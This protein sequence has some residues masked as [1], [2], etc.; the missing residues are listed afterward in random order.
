MSDA[1]TTKFIPKLNDITDVTTSTL[2]NAIWERLVKAKIFPDMAAIDFIKR[3]SIGN[4]KVLTPINDLKIVVSTLQALFKEKFNKCTVRESKLEEEFPGCMKPDLDTEFRKQYNI[5]DLI[6]TS[7]NKNTPKEIKT[8][9]AAA[10]ASAAPVTNPVVAV[11]ESLA[12]AASAVPVKKNTTIRAAIDALDAI[13]LTD[14]PQQPEQPLGVQPQQPTNP[15]KESNDP[16]IFEDAL[17]N[18][19][20]AVEAEKGE[21]QQD[22]PSDP[23]PPPA[24][25]AP[26]TSPPPPLN[27]NGDGDGDDPEEMEDTPASPSEDNT[28]A[29]IENLCFLSNTI[30]RLKFDC[31]SSLQIMGALNLANINLNDMSYLEYR[32]AID[33]IPN[34]ENVMDDEDEMVQHIAYENSKNTGEDIEGDT[35]FD[36]VTGNSP[37]TIAGHNTEVYGGYCLQ[38]DLIPLLQFTETVRNDA[39][40]DRKLHKILKDMS[41]IMKCAFG[42]PEDEF[43]MK[44]PIINVRLYDNIDLVHL[45]TKSLF[46]KFSFNIL[47]VK[48]D[49]LLQTRLL[50]GRENGMGFFLNDYVGSVLQPYFDSII[51]GGFGKVKIIPPGDTSQIWQIKLRVLKTDFIFISI[52]IINVKQEYFVTV[53]RGDYMVDQIYNTVSTLA[54]TYAVGADVM[55]DPETIERRIREDYIKSLNLCFS[56]YNKCLSKDFNALCSLSELDGIIAKMFIMNDPKSCEIFTRYIAYFLDN[57][58]DTYINVKRQYFYLGLYNL[59]VSISQKI[60]TPETKAYEKLFDPNPGKNIFHDS[61]N[62]IKTAVDN[63]NLGTC[64]PN[65]SSSVQTNMSEP[66]QFAM[67]GGKLYSLYQKA[68]NNFNILKIKILDLYTLILPET[69]EFEKLPSLVN[70][71]D[72]FQ[73]IPFIQ[74]YLQSRDK[75]NIHLREKINQL[76]LLKIQQKQQAELMHSLGDITD[77]S[78]GLNFANEILSEMITTLDDELNNEIGQVGNDAF[79]ILSTNFETPGYIPGN[80]SAIFNNIL[81]LSTLLPNLTNITSDDSSYEDSILDF[82]KKIIPDKPIDNHETEDEYSTGQINII[83]YFLMNFEIIRYFYC[84]NTTKDIFKESVNPAADADFSMFY[85]DTAL[86]ATSCMTICMI[87]QLAL[88]DLIDQ[89]VILSSPPNEPW[90]GSEIDIGNSCIGTPPVTLSSLRIVINNSVPFYNDIP[91]ETGSPYPACITSILSGANLT[92]VKSTISPFGPFAPP[93][94]PSKAKWASR[95]SSPTTA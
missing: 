27:D 44:Q 50:A 60:Y 91:P 30:S 7:I 10:T 15:Q 81:I 52:Q 54:T 18:I 11:S 3:K 1:Y 20:N 56:L 35:T 73:N 4:E 49:M 46:P 64:P 17:T 63:A 2:W 23:P 76:F 77:D 89:N 59:L 68:L 71:L 37:N 93:S 12:P 88:K 9:L 34:Y 41:N 5:M 36:P 14:P 45:D 95:I 80:I 82:F 28:C 57:L 32:S 33:S 75:Q 65:L 70:I 78:D 8:E 92:N 84:F 13:D 25:V 31:V 74:Q 69:T 55:A 40:T 58:V 19:E 86:G 43:N 21:M 87:L 26:P 79:S 72:N 85:E 22:H 66:I 42:I 24:A 16:D 53:G 90:N 94:R 48:S 29:G 61:M 38:A 67:G 39:N 83:K 62:I 6:R 47:T 51:T